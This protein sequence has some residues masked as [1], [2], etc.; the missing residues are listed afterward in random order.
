MELISGRQIGQKWSYNPNSDQLLTHE[1]VEVHVS[2][3]FEKTHTT[4]EY[5]LILS[6]ISMKFRQKLT[7]DYNKSQN[8]LKISWCKFDYNSNSIKHNYI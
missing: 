3:S 6:T 1:L 4:K 8:N 5:Y 2:N 7:S